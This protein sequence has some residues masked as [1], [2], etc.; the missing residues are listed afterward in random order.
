MRRT[1]AF[2]L[3]VYCAIVVVAHPRLA[4]AVRS[5]GI[6]VSD[7]Q[8]D[9]T[10]AN[11]NSIHADAKDFAWTKATEGGGFTATTFTNNMNR[12]T[13]AGVYMG[14]YHYA[15]PDL[16]SATTDAAHF[17]A[18]AG[19]YLG[20]GYLRPMLDIEGLSF[21]LST[22]ALSTWINDFCTYVTDRYGVGADPLI[23]IGASA[24]GSEVNSSVNIHGLDVAQWGSNSVDPAVP[25]GNP[26]TGVWNGNWAFWQYGSQGRV[27]GIGGGTANCDVDVANGDINYVRGFLIGGTLPP[28]SFERFDANGVTAGSGITNNGSYTWEGTKFSSSGA[29]TD[30]ATWNE[31]NF[32][33]LAAGAD[34]AANNYTITANSNHTF[35]GMMLQTDG[36]GTV[37]IGGT[38]VLSFSGD[39]G[40]FVTASTQNLKLSAVLA[41]SGKLVW[42]GSGSGTLNQ[43]GG[44]LFLLGNN[45]Y[46]GGT[47]LNAGSG[48]N[49]NNDHS[50]GTGRITWG[51]TGGTAT[52][53]V[54][55]N[56]VATG[57]V[58][59][60]NLVTTQA[61]ATLIYVGPAAAPVTFTGAWTLPSGTSTL[62]IGNASH[63]SSKMTISG[64]MGGSGGALTKSGVG[65][66]VLSGAN[67]YD[68]TTTISAG[69]FQLGNGGTTG[70]LSTASA[71][72]NNAS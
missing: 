58:T 49:F 52:Q 28:T 7:Y 40:F 14:A 29:G 43:S 19:P 22:T 21:N 34:A 8:G 44:S 60:A 48:V 13:A 36:G 31:G 70:K 61:S 54:L 56:D 47:A 12:G 67:T 38:G 32:L 30:A 11:W 35:A 25:T 5:A 17:V 63:T 1:I 23:Y 57:P 18:V 68:G 26:S 42:Q 64:A 15:R 6:D 53:Y 72:V 55:A 33:R 37:T 66:L 71:I 4:F 20:N 62:S 45:T 16:N 41:G 69:T 51:Y 2:R 39:Q 50:F 9:L 65:T 24:A 10:Q 46:T 3:F 59:L 27:N